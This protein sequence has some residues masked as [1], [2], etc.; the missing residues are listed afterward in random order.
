MNTHNPMMAE[1][2]P[3]HITQ[4]VVL[5]AYRV[6]QERLRVFAEDTFELDGVQASVRDI[7]VAANRLLEGTSIPLLNYPGVHSCFDRDAITM[8]LKSIK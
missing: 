1:A 7:V 8:R 6:L 3:S 4:P 2:I 5:M